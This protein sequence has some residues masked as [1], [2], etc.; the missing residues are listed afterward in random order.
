MAFRSSSSAAS[1]QPMPERPAHL[2][3]RAVLI[4]L[5]V[6]VI[7]TVLTT[8]AIIVGA[9]R[10]APYPVQYGKRVHRYAAIG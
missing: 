4:Q 6:F 3:C 8:R 9:G 5:I 2:R 1:L 10:S 7:V